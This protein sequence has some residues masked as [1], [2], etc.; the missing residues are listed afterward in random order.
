MVKTTSSKAEKEKR[1]QF[2][3]IPAEESTGFIFEAP[4]NASELVEQWL[5]I[6]NNPQTDHPQIT[7]ITQ[8]GRTAERKELM[9]KERI[10]KSN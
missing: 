4:L 6:T 2:R 3:V 9:G 1:R 10:A 5:Y 7:Q 8:N